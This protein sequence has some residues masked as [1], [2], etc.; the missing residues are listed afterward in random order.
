[1]HNVIVERHYHVAEH[2]NAA[3]GDETICRINSGKHRPW[4]MD[5]SVADLTNSSR[6]VS[7]RA[8]WLSWGGS[9]VGT[10]EVI[11]GL[12]GVVQGECK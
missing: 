3:K 8:G 12:G 9:G 11:E 6:T 1:M 2:C 7:A 4:G 5:V 10:M